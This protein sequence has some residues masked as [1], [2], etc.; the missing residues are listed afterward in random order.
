[1]VGKCEMGGGAQVSTTVWIL[2]GR[3]RWS[4]LG[5]LKPTLSKIIVMIMN[6]RVVCKP[7]LKKQWDLTS[8]S[9]KKWFS[10]ETK[11]IPSW[12]FFYSYSFSPTFPLS[13]SLSPFLPCSL[14]YPN[15]RE[16]FSVAELFPIPFLVF[17]SCSGFRKNLVICYF[18]IHYYWNAIFLIV[19]LSESF[20]V[21]WLFLALHGKS[22]WQGIANFLKG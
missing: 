13:L 9:Y 4:S 11:S 12:G 8:T 10:L 1:M 7:F 22:M 19:S 20:K 6:W 16:V 17:T 15:S 5:D 18:G 2:Q 3:S 14:L 21:N